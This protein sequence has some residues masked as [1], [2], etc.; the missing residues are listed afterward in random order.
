MIQRNGLLHLPY[1][2]VLN[3]QAR[4][5]TLPGISQPKQRNNSTT[6]AQ[7]QRPISAANTGK[8]RQHH[9]VRTKGVAVTDHDLYMLGNTAHIRLCQN[10]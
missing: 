1:R 5:R 3:I 7:I 10:V 9:G 6:C 4:H 8:I 2:L